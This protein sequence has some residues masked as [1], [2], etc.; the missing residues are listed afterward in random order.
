MPFGVANATPLF[1]E[2]MHQI[3]YILRRRPHCKELVSRG[4]KMEEHTVEPRY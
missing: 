1:Q 4:A 3:L 2:L